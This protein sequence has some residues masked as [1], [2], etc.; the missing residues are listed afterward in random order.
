M[1][2]LIRFINV[3]PGILILNDKL[4]IGKTVDELILIAEV[5]F[6]VEYQDKIV[7]FPLP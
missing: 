7:H 4:T 3:N 6:E 5:S 2:M 1:K